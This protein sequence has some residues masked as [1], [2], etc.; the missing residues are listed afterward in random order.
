[1]TLN[2]NSDTLRGISEKLSTEVKI[3]ALIGICMVLCALL[4]DFLASPFPIMA[5]Y[6]GKIYFPILA[7]YCEYFGFFLH[8]IPIKSIDWKNTHLESVLMPVIQYDSKEVDLFAGNIAPFSTKAIASGHY[9]GTDHL[10]RDVLSGLIHGARY[11]LTI[12]ISA[13]FIGAIIGSTIGLLAGYFG[14]GNK[15]TGNGIYIS[16]SQ[17]LFIVFYSLIYIYYIIF[18]RYYSLTDNIN[19]GFISFFKE[20]IIHF[21][22]SWIALKIFIYL[23]KKSKIKSIHLPIDL[24]LSR[25]IEFFSGIPLLPVLIAIGGITLLKPSIL[26]ITLGLFSWMGFARITRAETL[27]IRELDFI[28]SAQIS[29]ITSRR[30]LLK[31]ILPF[32]YPLVFVS[33]T[34]NVGAVILTESTLSFLGLGIPPETV[35]WGTILSSARSHPGDWWLSI[36]PG[37]MIFITVVILNI[38]GNYFSKIDN[39]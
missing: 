12:A 22:I 33:F 8:D 19:N 3:A 20:I 31:Q 21:S 17:L 9:F 35:T 38:I 18:L 5:Q 30:I 2:K 16:G 39:R 28:H 24:I 37:V 14:T 32:I 13:T 23:G 15:K 34:F 6:Q 4:A 27:K 25:I 11:S 29:G 36:F 26:I 10:G 1:M 7:T